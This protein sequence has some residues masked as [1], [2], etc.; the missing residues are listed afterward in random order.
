MR[1]INEVAEKMTRNGFKSLGCA[2]RFE[3]EFNTNLFIFFITDKKADVFPCSWGDIPIT[4]QCDGT[5]NCGDNSD[6]ENCNKG[7]IKLFQ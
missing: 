1:D 6:E 4:L 3:S 2:F 7:N 5:N